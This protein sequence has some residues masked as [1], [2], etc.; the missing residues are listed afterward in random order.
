MTSP[1]T[2]RCHRSPT[3]MYRLQAAKEMKSKQ[4]EAKGFGSV[5]TMLKSRN[6][7]SVGPCF[8]FSSSPHLLSIQSPCLQ[9]GACCCA[10]FAACH[11]TSMI[12]F[13]TS[14]LAPDGC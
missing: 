10:S 4:K 11:F 7:F 3:L 13:K 9:A 5:K 8:S 12:I 2:N 14:E 1:C 6:A